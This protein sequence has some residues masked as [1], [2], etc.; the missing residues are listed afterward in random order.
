MR[1]CSTLCLPSYSEGLPGVLIEALS[2]NKKII[3]TNSSLG[4]WEIMQC[5]ESYSER[6]VKP[7]ENELGFITSNCDD[8]D[9]C[10]NQLVFAFERILHEENDNQLPFNK[11]R[12]EAKTLSKHFTLQ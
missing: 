6:L 3:T 1:H 5:L 10:V 12:F 8:N 2:L 9:E 4:V 11:S 7:F